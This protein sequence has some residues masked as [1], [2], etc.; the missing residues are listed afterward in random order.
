M[1]KGG[2][3][4]TGETMQKWEGICRNGKKNRSWGKIKQ[5]PIFWIIVFCLIDTHTKLLSV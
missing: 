2:R 3:M 1:E 5:S 4:P